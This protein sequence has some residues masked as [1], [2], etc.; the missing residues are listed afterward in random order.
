M[1]RRLLKPILLVTF[2]FASVSLAARALGSTQ[3]P[4]LALGGFTVGCEDKPQPCWYGIVPG[5][6]T[7]EE[8][9]QIIAGLARYDYVEGF[10]I[11]LNESCQ[12]SYFPQAGGETIAYLAITPCEFSLPLGN[13][14]QLFDGSPT[15]IKV[16]CLPFFSISTDDILIFTKE[17]SVDDSVSRIEYYPDILQDSDSVYHHNK[18][19]WNGFAFDWFYTN[20]NPNYHSCG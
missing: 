12:V 9:N 8:A 14:L 17:I 13:V 5:V 1:T 3:P 16:N 10:G 6:T 11:Y 15:F 18:S 4:N 19:P 7:M 2:V 20:Q